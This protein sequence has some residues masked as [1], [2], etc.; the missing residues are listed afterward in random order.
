MHPDD[1]KKLLLATLADCE[2]SVEGDG[3]HF[4][5][6]VVGDLFAGLRPVQRQQKVYS[7]LQGEISKGAIHAVNMKTLT[8]EEHQ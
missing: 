8:P 7:V 5:I 2:V 1:V 6:M 3:R 4:D